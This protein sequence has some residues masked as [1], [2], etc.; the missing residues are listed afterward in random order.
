MSKNKSL[1]EETQK[2][3]KETQV[4][5]RQSEKNI[6]TC[7]AALNNLSQRLEDLVFEDSSSEI[8]SEDNNGDLGVGDHVISITNPHKGRTGELVYVGKYWARAKC[9]RDKSATF[10]KAKTN[11]RVTIENERRKDVNAEQRKTYKRKSAKR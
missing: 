3:M 2:E 6:K 5:L 9:D 11:F 4:K 10:K 1:I 8:S 7:Q